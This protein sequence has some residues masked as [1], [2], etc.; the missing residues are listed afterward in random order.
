MTLAI[1]TDEEV[2]GGEGGK[3]LAEN[4]KFRPKVL[5]VPDGGDGF[6][7]INKSKGVAHIQIESEGRPAHASV[8]WKGKNALV[9]LCQLV[10]LLLEKYD[11]NSQEENWETTMNIGFMAGGKSVNQVCPEGILKLDFRFPESR[12]VTEVVGEVT[13]LIAKVDPGLKLELKASGDPIYTD[14]N[15]PEV[16]KFLQ[17][18]E[19]ILGKKIEIKGE[20]GASDSRFWAKFNTLIIMTKPE[21][22]DIHSDNEWINTDSCLKFYALMVEYISRLR[23]G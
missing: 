22:G 20:Y 14:T 9:P 8:P 5:I 23:I 11:Q 13:D 1:T 21:G 6:E 4:L 19:K 15:L 7:L 3:Y 18:A 2:G 16:Q 12:N 10:N 17:A